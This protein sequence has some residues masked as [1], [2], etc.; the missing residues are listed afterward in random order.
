MWHRTF[1]LLTQVSVNSLIRAGW[2][3]QCSRKHKFK[4]LHNDPPK[5][6]STTIVWISAVT[7][8]NTK[9]NTGLCE[10]S[11]ST[12]C[13]GLVGQSD[14]LTLSVSSTEMQSLCDNPFWDFDWERSLTLLAYF[15][16]LSR[17]KIYTPSCKEAQERTCTIEKIKAILKEHW[18][19]EAKCPLIRIDL[20][21]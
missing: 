6:L 2:F 17:G 3:L 11:H 21:F 8:I 12:G 14:V 18:I 19:T 1:V 9:M 20:M 15:L 16:A 10:A 4:V 13:Q 7:Q 5:I